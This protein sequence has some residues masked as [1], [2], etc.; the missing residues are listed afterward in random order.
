[1]L[2]WFE[3]VTALH[4]RRR[5]QLRPDWTVTPRPAPGARLGPVTPLQ[6]TFSKPT[7]DVLGSDE[8]IE[9]DEYLKGIR[10]LTDALHRLTG[11]REET[12]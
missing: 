7:S 10:V 9:I 2:Q 12:T 4:R 3:K 6:L 8:H 1:M 5:Q 11:A